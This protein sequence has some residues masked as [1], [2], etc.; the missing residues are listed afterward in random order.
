M[1]DATP[2]ARS[3]FFDL[4]EKEMKSCN[5]HYDRIDAISY[6]YKA[7]VPQIPTHRAMLRRLGVAVCGRRID[8]I[9][10]W[11]RKPHQV[12]SDI[13]RFDSRGCFRI[14]TAR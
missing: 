5:V 11:Q 4:F 2:G 12:I 8:A 6:A 7:M 9:T 10:G 14:V 1:S 13:G 3:A